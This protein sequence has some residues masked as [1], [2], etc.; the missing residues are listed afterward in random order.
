[1]KKIQREDV[2]YS[3]LASALII[4]ITGAI[5]N[6]TF[7]LDIFQKI[8]VDS[9]ILFFAAI[10]LTE[11]LTTPPT[12]KLRIWYGI[13]VGALFAPQTHI[14][15]FYTTPEIALVL[16]NIYSYIVSPKE[17]LMLKLKE[18][19]PTGQNLY[20]FIFIPNKQFS[21][22][23]GQYME[24]TL[25]HPRADDRGNRRYF[26]LASSPTEQTVRLGIRFNNPA[27]SYKQ[28][29]HGMKPGS[30]IV[31]GQRSGDFVLPDDPKQKLVFIAGGI[32]ITPYRS[33]MKYLS[34]TKQ[35]RDIVL[36]YSNKTASEIVYRDI[37]D[38][39]Q[40]TIGA[41]IIY[42][43]TDRDHVPK[44]WT[45]LVGRIDEVTLLK[46]IPDYKERLFYISGP[47][48]LVNGFK[49]TLKTSGVHENMIKTDFFPG[50]M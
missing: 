23:P 28:S 27:S 31:A 13:L 4:T 18:I 44:N 50:F 8:F 20:D 32:G 29:L 24:W 15:S 40:K 10:M 42:T 11:P 2:V 34:D 33:I 1:V 46:E 38:E 47:N 35:Q 19:I 37:F 36:I 21:F 9:P 25:P 49:K 39:A 43:L 26:T 41:K 12:K 48:T 45:G 5:W 30:Q 17:K 16:G 7:S 6:N 14:G 22:I 3:F